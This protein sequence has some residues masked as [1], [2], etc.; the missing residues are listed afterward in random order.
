MMSGAAGGST[1]AFRSS[2]QRNGSTMPAFARSFGFG[3]E[4]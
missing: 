3:A 1:S 4:T 2:F